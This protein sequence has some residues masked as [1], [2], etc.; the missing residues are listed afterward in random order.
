MYF[1]KISPIVIEPPNHLYSLNSIYKSQYAEKSKTVKEEQEITCIYR[2]P[3]E[4]KM[5][6]YKK[7]VDK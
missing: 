5:C 4:L 7:L 2:A 1:N 3:M 6:H